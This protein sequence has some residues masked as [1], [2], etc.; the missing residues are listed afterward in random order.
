MVHRRRDRGAAA[1]EFALVL[2]VLLILV[3]GIIDFGRMLNAKITLTQAAREGARAA[4]VST[5]ANGVKWTRDAA[6][7][8]LGTLNPT[9]LS[10]ADD[11]SRTAASV[12][13]SYTFRFATPIG[14]MIGAGGT[15]TLT[16]EAVSPCIR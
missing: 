10:C 6:R 8:S 2:P 15:T 13:V 9:V 7:N 5:Q 3:F 14:A 11:P 1:V 4:A 16:S 12:T